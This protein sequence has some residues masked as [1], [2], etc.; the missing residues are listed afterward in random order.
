MIANFSD[1]LNIPQTLITARNDY[2]DKQPDITKRFLKGLVLGIHF[3]KTN[4]TD[5]IKAGFEAK[6]QGEAEIVQ[7]AYDLICAGIQRRS[8]SQYRRPAGDAR[9]RQ[10]Q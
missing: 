10:A 5:A 9:R 3:A 6:L 7:Q 2:L 8:V 4:K 1:T